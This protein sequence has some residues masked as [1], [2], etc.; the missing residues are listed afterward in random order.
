MTQADDGYL[1]DHVASTFHL[2]HYYRLIRRRDA[3]GRRH[4][5]ADAARPEGRRQLDAQSAGP[6][7]PRHVR[8]RVLPGAAR[9]RQ[10][11]GEK[12]DRPGGRVGLSC[13]NAD[14]GFGH[15]PGSPSD[16]DATYFQ[17]GVLVMA[18]FL[19][20]VD[21]PPKDPQ[22]LSWGHLFPRP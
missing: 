2:V 7:S 15:C 22:L 18:G 11:G 20:P 8:R 14:G 10:T 3:E 4:R 13:R 12:G 9:R 6:R 5:G 19:K 21:P 1:D 16:A 17:V